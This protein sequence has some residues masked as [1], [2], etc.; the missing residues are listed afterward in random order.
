MTH[1]EDMVM[2]SV[3]LRP[4]EDMKL[5]QLAHDLSMAHSVNVTKSDLIRSAISMKLQEWL[6]SDKR[7]LNIAD[8]V[9]R[10]EQGSERIK[11]DTSSAQ[12]RASRAAA[13][14][15]KT[16]AAPAVGRTKAPREEREKAD[17]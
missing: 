12:R 7:E 5:R 10:R 6:E 1:D 2:R 15:V 13:K 9:G 17:A 11:A 8:L 4:S 3:Y 16:S 14:A